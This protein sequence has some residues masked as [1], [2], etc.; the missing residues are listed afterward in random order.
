[1]FLTLRFFDLFRGDCIAEAR[2]SYALARIRRETVVRWMV[3]KDVTISSKVPPH[4]TKGELTT[5]EGQDNGLS[6]QREGLRENSR[7]LT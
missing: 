7:D 4:G 2:L 5:D 6:N 3:M 1:M